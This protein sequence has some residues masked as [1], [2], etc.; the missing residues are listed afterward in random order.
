MGCYIKSGDF[1]SKTFVVS[2]Y[3]SLVPEYQLMGW[4]PGGFKGVGDE[5]QEKLLI[6]LFVGNLNQTPR[7]WEGIP[8]WN[9]DFVLNAAKIKDLVT[10]SAAPVSGSEMLKHMPSLFLFCQFQHAFFWHLSWILQTVLT[11]SNGRL[12]LPQVFIFRL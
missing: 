4:K 8:T 3:L 12:F 1:A 2:V 5:M 6:C 10:D 9:S 7:E 11:K